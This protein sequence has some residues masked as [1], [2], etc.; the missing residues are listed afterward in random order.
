MMAKKHDTEESRFIK[1][2]HDVMSKCGYRRD[3]DGIGVCSLNVAPCE[4]VLYMGGCEAVAKWFK[5]GEKE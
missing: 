5:E 4:K 1:Q 2:I 3:M